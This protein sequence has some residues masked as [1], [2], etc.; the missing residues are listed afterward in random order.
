MKPWNK[1]TLKEREYTMIEPEGMKV[2]LDTVAEAPKEGIIVIAGSAHGGDA[3]A[4]MKK[5]PERYVIVIDSFEGLAAPTDGDGPE[6]EKEGGHSCG[7]KD[8][9]IANFAELDRPLPQ[10]LIKMW[11]TPENLKMLD[12]YDYKVAMLF[13]DLDHYQPVKACL[14]YFWPRLVPK[15]KVLTHDWKFFRTEGV[16]RACEE[17]RP[18]QWDP[19]KGFGKFNGVIK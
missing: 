7:G 10:N 3:M 4:I 9:Y 2:V 13:M 18:R 1:L 17:F 6:V 12:S 16:E 15:A 5:Y 19:I 8:Q 11:I 14:E